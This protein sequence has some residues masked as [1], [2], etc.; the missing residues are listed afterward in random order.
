MSEL[1]LVSDHSRRSIG[2]MRMRLS[3]VSSRAAAFVLIM[4]LA[5]LCLAQA[6]RRPP[7]TETVK[8]TQPAPS[9][10]PNAKGDQ[11]DQAIKLEATLIS[12][13]VIASDHD[14]RYVPD[15]RR[16][17]FTIHEDGVKQEIVFFGTI[18]EPFHVVLMLDTS[19]STQEKLGQIRQ[20]ALTF[21]DQLKPAD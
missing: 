9:E 17:D 15:M 7:Q 3:H 14:G 8:K 13:P 21:V 18:N 5:T 1:L 4:V 19:A 16:E 6:G 2:E 10:D 12:V 20:A 11:A